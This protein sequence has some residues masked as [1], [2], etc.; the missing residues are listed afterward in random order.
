MKVL[1]THF[2]PS[3]KYYTHGEYETDKTEL[4]AIHQQV[5]GFAQHNMLPGLAPDHSD[6]FTL[7]GV[8]DHPHDHP[9]LV[10][11]PALRVGR[12]GEHP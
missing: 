5:A 9:H 8:P 11:P 6:F 2:K 10:V 7:V 3:G 12:S 4:F 1:L